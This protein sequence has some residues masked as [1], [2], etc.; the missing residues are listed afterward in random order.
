MLAEEF[1]VCVFEASSIFD[2][3]LVN[4]VFQGHKIP[5]AES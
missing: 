1:V 2:S 5:H 3:K 4:P